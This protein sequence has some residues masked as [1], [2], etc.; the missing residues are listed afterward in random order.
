MNIGAPNQ[1]FNYFKDCYKSDYKEFKIK[2]ILDKKY[3][4]KWFNNDKEQLLNNLS[5]ILFYN[6]QNTHKLEKD[7]EIYQL[8]KSLYYGAFF[9]IG[10]E[11][12]NN[13]NKDTTICSPLV[14]Y[15]CEI[16][17]KDNDKFIKINQNDCILNTELCN[18][19]AKDDPSK[20]KLQT[21]LTQTL[22]SPVVDVFDITKILKKHSNSLDTSELLLY[23]ENWSIKKI[24]KT[25]KNTTSEKPFLIIPA[26]GTI[27]VPKS[28]SSTKVISD[29]SAIAEIDSFNTPLQELFENSTLKNTP[30]KSY[31][32]NLLNPEQ[33]KAL[34]NAQEYHNSIIIGPPGTGKSYTI[35]AIAV[36]AILKGKSVLVVSKTK[37]AV[38]VIRKNLIRDF[39]LNDT[40]IHTSGY[41]Y[42]ISLKAK[43]KRRLSGITPRN[44]NNVTFI[45]PLDSKAHKLSLK[46]KKTVERELE[47][48]DINLKDN[49]SLKEYLKKIWLNYNKTDNLDF[50]N[51]LQEINE[52]SVELYR[53]LIYYVKTTINK[54][55]F[56]KSNDFRTSLATYFEALNATSF[57]E[58]QKIIENLDFNKIVSIFPIWLAHLSE[59]N[60]V[61]PQT[62]EL[63]DL[64][65]I[66][67]AT[68]CDI[69]TALPAI[70]RAK[71]VVI[72][73]DP[74]QLRHYSFI[75]QQHQIN[76]Q[77]KNGLSKSPLFDYR[78]KSILDIYLTNLSDQNQ[79]SFLRE[80]YRSTPSLIEFN[81]QEFYDNQ[82]E[83]IKSTTEFT[84]SKQIELNYVA[85]TRNS[86]GIN[87][88]EAQIVISKLKDL[89]TIHDKGIS[90]PSIGII[91]PFN[92]Q[93]KYINKLIGL[94][95]DLKTI[96]EFQILCG[97]PYNFQGSEREIII[98]SFTVCKQTHHA[99]FTHLNK[100]EVLNVG[101]TRAKSFQYI[102]TSIDKQSLNKNSLFLK[103]IDFIENF[104]YDKKNQSEQSDKFQLEVSEYLMELGIKD[105]HCGYPFAGHILDV[106]LSH[107]NKN[108]FIDLIGYQ[109][110]YYESF[111][112]ERYKTFQRVGLHILPLHYR[113]W[114]ENNFEAKKT[115][116]TLLK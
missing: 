36:D 23:P 102:Y 44:T 1:V 98:I 56:E 78:N 4:Y 84:N 3:K 72:C 107:Q 48:T 6:N 41:R 17:T 64:V 109:G 91:S 14:L 105:I 73:G 115:L 43:I 57:S 116:K 113:F 39:Q 101:T 93:A 29:L 88:I 31:L 95:F 112:M 80:H 111:S 19:F 7:L 104:E 28:I 85:G 68:Q 86:K 71:R 103:Y 53:E 97:T 75:S 50:I 106:F 15:P 52:N 65:I 10:K 99:A 45:K 22:S 26:S 55:S 54:Q 12:E 94:N 79:I 58:S 40:L 110:K 32:K 87:E 82:L 37:Q 34:N 77:L 35:S 51:T 60:S 100:S 38:E 67:E 90:K 46:F 21:L 9:I 2:N 63:F 49:L 92:D 62:Q 69:A 66:D 33:F 47:F 74:N 8:E 70:F 83:I 114:N 13:F 20:E 5:P 108:Y 81:N 16:E 89:T 96:K 61:F 59:L 76:L 25:I 24:R 11:N 27:L 18:Q 30:S 42:K